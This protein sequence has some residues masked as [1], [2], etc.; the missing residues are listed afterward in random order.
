MKIVGVVQL[1]YNYSNEL[2]TYVFAAGQWMVGVGFEYRRAWHALWVVVPVYF[3]VDFRASIELDGR[4]LSDATKKTY[5]EMKK[6]E[7]ISDALNVQSFVGTPTLKLTLMPGVGIYGI[8]GARGEIDFLA[9][10]RIGNGS[11]VKK[12]SGGGVYGSVGGGVGVDLL[13]MK[14]KKEIAKVEI[15]TG[16]FKENKSLKTS[17]STGSVTS[18]T[19]DAIVETDRL[20]LFDLEGEEVSYLGTD[21]AGDDV[22]ESAGLGLQAPDSI[23]KQMIMVDNCAE[24]V[25][26]QIAY[27]NGTRI[28]TYLSKTGTGT[29]NIAYSID[30]G[31]GF[32][33]AVRIDPDNEGMDST[34][35]MLVHNG[36]V[37]IAWSHT[38]TLLDEDDIS[39][40]EGDTDADISKAKEVLKSSNIKLA[41]YDLATEKLSEPITVTNDQFVNSNVKVCTSGDDV[42][43]YYYKRDITKATKVSELISHNTNYSSW[44]SV[45]Y[46]TKTGT[47]GKETYVSI[48]HPNITDPLVLT[49]QCESCTVD[50]DE[51][52]FAVYSVDRNLNNSGVSSVI[53]DKEQV[54]A[55]IWLK[56]KNLTEN[57]DF[58]PLLLDSGNVGDV[59]INIL[60]DRTMV[61]WLTDLETL[62]SFSIDSVF[63]PTVSANGIE[64]P[65]I[66]EHVLKG[67]TND[68][69]IKYSIPTNPFNFEPDEDNTMNISQYQVVSG[70]DGN[71]YL[72]MLAPGEEEIDVDMEGNVNADQG[73][74]IYGATYF[75]ESDDDE[76]QE[77]IGWGDMVQ[78][79]EYKKAIDEIAVAV[80]ENHNAVMVANIF[81]NT[82]NENG[83]DSGNYKLVELDCK[84]VSSLRIEEEPT[85]SYNSLY[86]SPGEKVD[87]SFSIVNEG[88]IP[89]ENYRI[90]VVQNVLGNKTPIVDP[91]CWESSGDT[92]FSGET[93]EYTIEWQIPDYADTPD[94]ISLTVSVTE[95]EKDD[96][97]KEYGTD[98]ATL[99]LEGDYDLE[100]VKDPY[101][102]SGQELAS[103]LDML[104]SKINSISTNALTEEEALILTQSFSDDEVFRYED[105]VNLYNVNSVTDL[106]NADKSRIN[107]DDWYCFVYLENNGNMDAAD[108]K[109]TLYRNTTDES[110]ERE[111]LGESDPVDMST[112]SSKALV[113]PVDG[114][115]HE[116][117]DEYGVL[118]GGVDISVSEVT[119][120][121]QVCI[122][123]YTAENVSLSL[124]DDD[125]NE[126]EL[127][128]GDSE[129]LN[130]VSKPYDKLKDLSYTSSDF[131]VAVVSE[132]GE[133]TAVGQ[134]TAVISV[135]DANSDDVEG[136]KLDIKVTVTS[137]NIVSSLSDN[138]LTFAGVNEGDTVYL[139]KGGSY[140]LESGLTITSSVKNAVS[141]KKKNNTFKVK[142]DT[143]LTLTK[144]NESKS[145]KILAV[146]VKKSAQTFTSRRRYI[147][148]DELLKSDGH[149]LPDL[150]DGKYSV[151]VTDKKGILSGIELPVP[152]SVADMELNDFKFFASGNKGSATVKV[153]IGS[154]A[155]KVTLKSTGYPLL[156]GTDD[157]NVVSVFEDNCVTFDS[158]EDLDTVV[159]LKNG[160]YTLESGVTAEPLTKN[161]VKVNEKT[162][163]L[164]LK[165]ETVLKLS[166]TADGETETKTVLLNYVKIKKKTVVLAE[167]LKTVKLDQLY[168]GA[169]ELVPDVNTDE[170]SYIISVKDKKGVLDNVL[171]PAYY[172][173]ESLPKLSECSLNATGN[174][175]SATVTT[176]FGGKKFNATVKYK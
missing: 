130:I 156:E 175:G 99:D 23:E 48:K 149:I 138:R 34:N 121:D 66:F 168:T 8:L 18:D 26:P 21:P 126:L 94:L 19:D 35:D 139:L 31:Y 81:E 128:E 145:I 163:K 92:I 131:N 111:K 160:K 62:N 5:A 82:I 109:A 161:A 52:E 56:A 45:K 125:D 114:D 30:K 136:K 77:R 97:S 176:T 22:L 42:V 134:G 164:S 75:H 90:D 64:G 50:D 152:E 37:Y 146:T 142:K 44:A 147:T 9:T 112:D 166:R 3:A 39:Y 133:V 4:W 7:N 29:T 143:A 141:F 79:T 17:A 123:D 69:G 162:R 113:I 49:Y 65:S 47:L 68:N 132:D 25:R 89:A 72:F 93:R 36:K 159:L 16:V 95:L 57:K 108:V 61:T 38:D 11:N 85:L 58:D 101:I 169:Y 40:K 100:E 87:V 78:V 153:T 151:T 67:D 140:E 117:Y 137:N 15:R 60:S 83:L 70:A 174:K 148:L 24:Y 118:N 73:I 98:S 102:V 171:I 13:C 12:G 173:Y 165:K 122:Y 91:I 53:N 154:K 43:M 46:D 135:Y 71:V 74:E 106:R 41:V 127:K 86:P 32:S 115:K 116:I 96:D 20:E 170:N 110:T 84:P 104:K 157:E 55:E 129:M 10:A 105:L 172:E 120:D 1:M 155:F 119:T 76:T 80:D 28:L 144:G 54:D 14:F 158:L 2:N 51:W 103:Y 27:Y 6:T 167:D 33:K 150:I 63:E 59:K 88:L 124:S 107:E